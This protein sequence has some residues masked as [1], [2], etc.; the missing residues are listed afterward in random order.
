MRAIFFLKIFTIGFSLAAKPMV[1][2]AQSNVEE[3]SVLSASLSPC[4]IGDNPQQASGSQTDAL[5]ANLDAISGCSADLIDRAKRLLRG[6]QSADWDGYNQ[7]LQRLIDEFSERMREVAG[8]GGV[9]ELTNRVLSKK[10]RELTVAEEASEAPESDKDVASLRQQ[11]EKLETVITGIKD[12]VDGINE[13]ILDI[14]SLRP[15]IARRI[16]LQEEDEFIKSAEDFQKILGQTR[17]ELEAT[18]VDPNNVP[19]SS[20]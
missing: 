11:T 20:D 2:T 14:I 4:Q 9:L 5:Q 7:D 6:D 12:E 1:A 17:A 16:R 18:R 10:K 19:Q 13:A 15:V 8:S 3:S